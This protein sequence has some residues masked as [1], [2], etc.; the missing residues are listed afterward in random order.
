MASAPTLAP[1]RTVE[2]LTPEWASHALGRRVTA[3]ETE[4]VGTG[5][6]GRVVRL[7][8]TLADG[9]QETVIA[10][11]AAESET[12]RRT[13]VAM[14][15]YEA[16]VRFYEQIAPT[17]AIDV[18]RCHFAA[19]EP[20]S[21]WFT[22]VFDDLS[23]TAT[24]GDMVAGGTAD[25]AAIA[26]RALA[27]LQGP[28]WD[29][30]A[31]GRLPW[32]ADRGRTE[33]LFGAFAG[34]AP[35]FLADLGDGLSAEQVA[36]IERAVPKALD[37]IRGWRGPLVVQHGDFRLD[38]M[39][40]ANRLDTPAVTVV[41]WQ[42]TR[43][44]P[45]L[46]DAAFYL[47]GCLPLEQRRIHERDLLREYHAGLRTHGVDGYPFDALWQDYRRDC[48]LGLHMAVGTYAMVEQDA[49]GRALYLGA[50]RAYADL[51]IDLASTELL[52]G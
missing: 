24:V 34:T 35:R 3:T 14:G 46:V 38:N 12:S 32:L 7:T 18:P 39:L 25:E 23:S 40:F 27:D 20:D 4:V 1:A 6:L 48:L 13:G 19:Y 5:Q 45:P 8:L 43:L 10:K 49:R 31:L 47:G 51:A 33:A 52:P 37:W 26:L 28:R 41:D 50:A 11:L 29:D 15:V 16:E 9:D 2:D 21:G 36:V 17:V 30:P 44:G 42:T 22:L